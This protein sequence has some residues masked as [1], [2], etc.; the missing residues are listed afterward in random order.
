MQSGKVK[1]YNQS[2][3]YGFIVPDDGSSDIFV[4]C[5]AVEKANMSTLEVGQTIQYES[6]TNKGRVNAVNLKEVA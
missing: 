2:K 3:G 1:F 4:H 6:A 5:S